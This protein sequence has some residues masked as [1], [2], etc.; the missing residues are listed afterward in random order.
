[1]PVYTLYHNGRI[2]TMDDDNPR[3][4]ALAV[5]DGRIL[6]V[7]SDAG[8]RAALAAAPHRVV[9]LGGRRVLPG[10]IDAHAHLSFFSM[11]HRHLR[12]KPL[13]SVSEIVEAVA[14][15]AAKTPAGAW[16]RGSG[17]NHLTL[18]ERR[19]PTRRELDRAA[20]GHPVILTRTCGHI[21]SVNT[22]ALKRA[23]VALD[24]PDPPGG[25][26][27]R[28]ADGTLNGVLYD[29]ALAEIQQASA[30]DPDDLLDWMEDGARVWARAGIVAF[31]DAGGPP[32]YF[33]VLARAYREGRI[34]QRVD[35]M[36]W[37]GLGIN[38]LAE[39][40]PSRLATGF[41]RGDF[42]IGA[43]KVMLD[44][45]SSGPTAATREPY[46]VNP[47]F[48]GILYHEEAEVRAIMAEAAEAGFQLTAHAVGDRA[49]AMAAAVIGAVGRRERRNRI[50][51]CAMCPPDL[52]ALLVEHAITP[53]AQPA[54]LH[55]FGDTYVE[56]YGA[57]RGAALFPLRSWMAAGLRVAGSSD[58]PVT[59]Y[60][61]LAGIAAAV[62][63]VTSSGQVLAPHERLTLPDALRLYTRNPAWLAGAEEEWGVLRP[64]SWAN[65][66]V[67]GEDLLRMTEPA[68]MRACPVVRTVIK[69]RVVWDAEGEPDP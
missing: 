37:N 12:L 43:A 24:A 35:A 27:G 31:H 1:M 29:Q 26:L 16:I 60:R 68:D 62:G 58:S 5:S 47:A 3:A 67:L 59:D 22:E 14:A 25:R 15:V 51:H 19:H 65:L 20:P 4:E 44:G 18:A 6:Y 61:P 9:D 57:E 23:G 30:P 48:S 2:A 55:E 53:V 33:G 50:E 10:F 7:G 8:A 66:V 63:R 56:S 21:A 54:F 17:Y 13:R 11:E 39:F 28:E 36:V 69:D 45:S 52:R 32:G 42:H 38:Q 40:L 34:A 64:G 46:R 49:V 41:H